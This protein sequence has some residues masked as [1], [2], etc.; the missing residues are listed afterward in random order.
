[1]GNH[2]TEIRSASPA[3]RGCQN[4]FAIAIGRRAEGQVGQATLLANRLDRYQKGGIYVDNAG[5]RATIRGNVVQGDGPGNVIAQ[6]GIQ[7]SRQASA[8]VRDN[9][10]REHAYFPPVQPC[11]PFATC[12]T[13]TG[14]I[15]FEVN[16]SVE[17]DRN[18]LRR[19][20]DGVGIY[21]ATANT[22]S[23]NRIIGGIQPSEIPG[24][25]LGDGIFADFDTAGNRIVGNFL[26]DNVE[27]DCHDDSV[28]PNNPPALVANVWRENDG[29]TENRPG[30]CKGARDDDDDDDEDRGRGDRD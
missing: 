4:G 9:V 19:N 17:I 22:V 18:E 1:V 28:G 29:E 25:T 8:L 16:G 12:V 21:T 14:I 13:A 30:L 15:V 10:I 24:S 27:H 2:V 3:L 11:V 7:I 20:Q 23:D 5:S 26:R 6:N